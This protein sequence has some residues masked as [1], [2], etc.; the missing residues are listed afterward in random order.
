MMEYGGIWEET[1]P[2]GA[3]ADREKKFRQ[4]TLVKNVCFQLSFRPSTMG[5]QPPTETLVSHT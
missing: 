1:G 4:F 3:A 5:S 2:G